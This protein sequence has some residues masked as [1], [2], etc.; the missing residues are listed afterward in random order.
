[1]KRYDHPQQITMDGSTRQQ[2]LYDDAIDLLRMTCP[3]EGFYLATSF[4]KD[5]IVT[6]RLLDEAGVK[7]DAH[8][9]H[10]GIDPPELIW[11]GRKYYPE[12]KRESAGI[13]MWRLIVKKGF[14]PMRRMRYCCDV[15]KEDGGKG[16]TCVMGL[17][18]AE[19]NRRKE[20]WAPLVEQ[21]QKKTREGTALRLFD[22]DDIR[23]AV[24]SCVERGKW[25]VSPLYSW[26]ND[27]LWAFIRDRRLPYC[28]LYD[29]GFERLGC[30]GCPMATRWMREMEFE[31]W[32]KFRDAYVRAFGRLIK[33][34]RFT[35]REFKAGEDVMQ[36][37]L[38]DSMQNRPIEGQIN[39][40]D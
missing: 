6:H 28:E 9:N 8:N 20:Q 37:W 13:S 5:S 26:N 25:T 33:A 3:P 17:R 27:D 39:I 35:S 36:W 11:F 31:R 15:L 22:A 32:P 1:M 34:G 40:F 24:Q 29:Q 10:T 23:S 18:A 30:I 12:V 4:G 38:Q 14:P 21:N 2:K 19:S 7:Y 16:R